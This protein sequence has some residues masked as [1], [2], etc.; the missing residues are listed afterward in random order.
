MPKGASRKQI[1]LT[2]SKG[3]ILIRSDKEGQGEWSGHEKVY[4]P[5]HLL[6][7][8]LNDVDKLTDEQRAGLVELTVELVNV[9]KTRYSGGPTIP[10]DQ[11]L[12]DGID[13]VLD[14]NQKLADT[15]VPA[16]FLEGADLVAKVCAY[17][18][19]A[20]EV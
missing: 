19:V 12:A 8:R 14:I 3:V 1:Y 5:S 13:R 11:E 20:T 6:I 4:Q 10:F 16:R 18:S 9:Y 17:H 7:L 2:K 15:L